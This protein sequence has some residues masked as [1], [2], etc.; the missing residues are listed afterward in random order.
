MLDFQAFWD[1]FLTSVQDNL[2]KWVVGGILMVALPFCWK[3][4]KIGWKNWHQNRRENANNRVIADRVRDVALGRSKLWDMVAKAGR[5]AEDGQGEM[6][7]GFLVLN[8][9]G[10]VGKTTTAINLA[11]ALVA[12][13]KK[14]L[15]ADLDYQGNLTSN[16]TTT[17]WSRIRQRAVEP[18]R[19]DFNTLG[20]VISC[21]NA[22]LQS[23]VFSLGDSDSNLAGL[24]ILGSDIALI[25]S[26]DQASFETLTGEAGAGLRLRRALA[27]YQ[28][29]AGQAPFDFV[30]FDCPPRL[31]FS[32]LSAFQITQNIVIPTRGDELSISGLSRLLRRLTMLF[33]PLQR[34]ANVLGVLL[35]QHHSNSAERERGRLRDALQR[36]E[37]DPEVTVPVD[38]KL[39]NTVIPMNRAISNPD[40]IVSY[41][42][43]N[44]VIGG[45]DGQS[46]RATYDAL[47]DEILD[48]MNLRGDGWI[49]K[50]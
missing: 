18:N 6:P 21:D 49:S 16:Y 3:W 41:F 25:E 40:M 44:M 15:V 20:E 34:Q 46:V 50:N 32:T 29:D 23:K 45:K 8:L 43:D 2:G 38:G 10:G 1:A 14:V 7:P 39:F 5:Q 11:A 17:L 22:A 33:L 13:G 9:K 42:N 31:S 35:N 37:E 19:Y 27:D 26:E 28:T 47:L 36:L 12:R 24:Y 48:R 30:I 4:V